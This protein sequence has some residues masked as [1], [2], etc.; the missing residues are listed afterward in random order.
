MTVALQTIEKNLLYWATTSQFCVNNPDSVNQ[1]CTVDKIQ[2]LRSSRR[3]RS[4]F[5]QFVPRV[6]HRF[7]RSDHTSTR[8]R[9]CEETCCDARCE[10]SRSHHDTRGGAAVTERTV[11]GA[12]GTDWYSLPALPLQGHDC[13]LFHGPCNLKNMDLDLDPILPIKAIIN[14]GLKLNR[15]KALGY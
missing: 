13:N 6:I 7:R 8:S 15:D 3:R 14:C 9:T 4:E 1:Y 12:R 11:V 2:D 5:L 10:S